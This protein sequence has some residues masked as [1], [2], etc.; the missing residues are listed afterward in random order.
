MIIKKIID[1]MPLIIINA[2]VCFFIMPFLLALI[3]IF[4]S[5]IIKRWEIIIGLNLMIF[6]IHYLVSYS[7]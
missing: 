4:L 7:Y 3:G 5:L 2:I 1:D 6:Y